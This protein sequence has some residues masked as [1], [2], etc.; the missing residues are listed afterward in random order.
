MNSCVA[1][2]VVADLISDHRA[3]YCHFA[4]HKPPF[5]HEERTYRKVKA[6]NPLSFSSDIINSDLLKKPEHSVEELVCQY[7]HVLI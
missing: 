6:F 5:K 1:D 4:M 7:D 2:T 3:V